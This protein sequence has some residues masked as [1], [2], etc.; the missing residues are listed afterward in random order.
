MKL[1]NKGFS[2]PKEVRALLLVDLGMSDGDLLFVKWLVINRQLKC[3]L[4]LKVEK[5]LLS[6]DL[7]LFLRLEGLD[8]VLFAEQVSLSC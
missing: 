6:N 3:N 5:L 8:H 7:I 4:E 1:V 2:D